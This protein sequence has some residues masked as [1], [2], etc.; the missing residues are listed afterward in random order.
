MKYYEPGE[1]ASALKV[2]L[3]FIYQ[4]ISENRLECIKL[5]SN[6]RITEKEFERFKDMFFLA[7]KSIKAN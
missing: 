4:M 2:N 6:Y 3:S 5:G 7:S 1:I